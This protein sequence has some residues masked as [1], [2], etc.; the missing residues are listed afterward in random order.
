[1]KTGLK[2]LIYSI[3]VV[4]FVIGSWSMVKR[5]PEVQFAFYIP[6]TALV[7]YTLI[8]DDLFRKTQVRHT[9]GR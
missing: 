1:M 6:A 8:R 3:G 7:I 2:A 4:V 5:H 9:R